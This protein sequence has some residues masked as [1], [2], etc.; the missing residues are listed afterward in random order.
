MRTSAYNPSTGNFV[1]MEDMAH[2]RWYP[3]STVLG[4]GRVM[5]FSGV[6]EFGNTDTHVEI[7]KVG[8]GWA[9]A[10]S[11]PWTPPL[12]PRMHLLPSGKVFYSGS[13]TQSRTFDPVTGTWSTVI[14]TTIYGGERT[15]GSSVLLPLTPAN[16]YKLKV[17]IF[18]GGNPSTATTE[19]IDLSATIPVWTSGPPMAAPRIEMNATLLP[20]GKILTAGGSLQDED[21]ST[22]SLKADL[23]DS[24]T[25]TMGSAGSNAFLRLYHSVSLLLPDG[26]VWVAGGNPTRGYGRELA[27]FRRMVAAL[28]KPGASLI[29]QPSI[30][31]FRKPC[32]GPG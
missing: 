5:T 32:V 9:V 15:Y 31:R 21:Y 20:N 12:Y 6:D 27:N 26:T 13:T 25:N 2:G 18:G 30:F 28:R 23:N 4:D 7:Y 8:A 24:G 10:T 17:M 16:S 1:D 22:A 19:I 11:L 3:T 14:A 29:L